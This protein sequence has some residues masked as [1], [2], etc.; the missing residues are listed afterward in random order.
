M[1]PEQTPLNPS[2][3]EALGA[4]LLCLAFTIH[5]MDLPGTPP[6]TSATFLNGL[7]NW[8]PNMSDM[9]HIDPAGLDLLVAH[10]DDA[11]VRARQLR[12]TDGDAF[13]RGIQDILDNHD[14]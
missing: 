8:I 6:V 2:E 9:L 1:T 11:M 12:R 13:T 4:F 10:L 5:D 3:K 7:R 14:D